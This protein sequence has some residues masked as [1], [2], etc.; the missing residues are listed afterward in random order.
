MNQRDI[1][2]ALLIVAILIVLYLWKSG[3][4][5]FVKSKATNYTGSLYIENRKDNTFKDVPV[6]VASSNN[7]Q[8]YNSDTVINNWMNITPELIH[9]QSVKPNSKVT[10]PIN[11]YGVFYASYNSCALL[12]HVS[13]P[14]NFK[15]SVVTI[16][17]AS[18]SN[19]ENNT[20]DDSENLYFAES[21]IYAF[22]ILVNSS[23]NNGGQVFIYKLFDLYESH[24]PALIP[25]TL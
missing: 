16:I 23:K 13:K 19:T 1:Y 17:F 11:Y 25:S 24:S 2:I 7:Y 18:L 14:T 15:Q 9:T 22:I 4:L 20:T 6:W 3:K 8:V 5:P 10:I 21:S 12:F